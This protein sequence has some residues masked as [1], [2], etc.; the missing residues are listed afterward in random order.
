MQSLDQLC[1]SSKSKWINKK[2]RFYGE[3]VVKACV[4]GGTH[5]VDING[6]TEFVERMY[7]KYNQLATEAKVSI[8]ST[9]GFDCIPSEMGLAF[10][11]EQFKKQGFTASVIILMGFI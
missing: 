7:L 10:M 2:F 11:K 5:Y 1:G 9:C 3:P 6:E 4:E 8:V